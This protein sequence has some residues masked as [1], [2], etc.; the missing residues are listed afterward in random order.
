VKLRFD[1]SPEFERLLTG[2]SD[3]CLAR[4][5]LEIAHDA[6]PELDVDNYLN[7]I[8]KL[9]DRIR[10]RCRAEAKIHHVIS[11]INWV[12]FVEEE[13]HGNQAD[14]YDPRNSYLNEVLDRRLGIPISLSVL[15]WAIAEQLGL[16][17]AGVNLPLHF[18]LRVE[19]AG[20]VWFVDPFH[21]GAIYDRKSCERL[22]A[23]L[24][25]HPVN[26]EESKTEP[27]SIPTVVSRILRNLRSIYWD[28]KD[29]ASV[30]PIQ[31]RLAALNPHK[32]SEQRDLGLLCSQ[33]GRLGEAIDPLES[34]LDRSPDARDADDI[35]AIVRAL[36]SQ[37]ARWN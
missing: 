18:M 12:L 9:G 20:R 19:D 3:V 31:R 5:A 22:L 35:R 11:Q 21:A 2:Q 24:A 17:M 32:P 4:I 6:Y 33:L 36:R 23:K 7:R 34:Y 29:V 14:Y 28:A 25:K 1:E 15:Y 10:D 26:L 37:V 27:C 8:A 13:I 30:L 16:T